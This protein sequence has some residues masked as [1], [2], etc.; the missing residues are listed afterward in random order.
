MSQPR[1]ERVDQVREQG[2]GAVATQFLRELLGLRREK[3]GNLWGYVF[4]A[5]AVLLY[6]VFQA[7][8][9]LRGL[10]MA[11]SDY[12]WLIPQTH[13]WAGFNGLANWVEM[14]RDETFWQSFLI[15]VKFSLMFVPLT[16]ILS[17]LTAVLISQI[18]NGFSAA[19]YRVIAYMPVIL[20]ISIGMLVW[21]KLFDVRFGYLNVLL[22]DFGMANPPNWLGSPKMAL[23]TMVLPTVWSK[24]GSWTLL[25]L[26]GIY[27]INREIYEAARVDGAS[28]WRQFLNITLPLLKPVFTL[29]LVL[30]SGVVSVTEESMLLFG[31]TTGGPAESALTTGVYLYRT[32]FIHGDMRMGYAAT[33][34]LFLGLVNMLI[35]VF[36]FT[37][38][39]SER[40]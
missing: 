5:P 16:L 29:V 22:Q 18:N 13:G 34:S 10:F 20:P 3:W 25:F 11:F 38:L 19:I 7:W 17:L 36:V 33:L 9:I 12:R 39:R 8:P 35:T 1:V 15:A 40:A 2:T 27:N 21:V 37:T 31:G 24:F 28:G 4:I 30:G 14:F 23:Y 32:A 6:F 26:I